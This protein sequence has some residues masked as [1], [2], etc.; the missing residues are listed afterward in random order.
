MFALSAACLQSQAHSSN[1]APITLIMPYQFT[2]PADIEGVPRITK[3]VN[4]VQ[5][6]STPAMTDRLAQEFA[7]AL[8]VSFEQT[9]RV[10]RKAGGMGLDG[11]R[12]VAQAAPDGRTLLFAGN[13]LMIPNPSI[14]GSIHSA[15]LHMLAPAAP[16]AEMPLVLV[17][18]RDHSLWTVRQLVERSQ[19]RAMPINIGALGD[20][21]TSHLAVEGLGQLSGMRIVRVGYN[22]S[23]SV[24]N[25][26]AARN[27]EFGVV[28]LTTV[29][30]YADGG[31]LK[32]IGITSKHRHPALPKVA[33]IAESGIG[34]YAVSG[35]FGLFAP[36]HT[37]ASLVMLLNNEVQRAMAEEGR[38]RRLLA[39]GLFPVNAGVEE[40]RLLIERD[41]LRWLSLLKSAVQD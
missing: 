11:V 31:R 32:I 36:A 37:D 17:N 28:P 25:A 27:V 16:L 38:Q 19:R 3:M 41:T 2:G 8:S 22:S 10:E 30:P 35:W 18:E 12:A 21:T 34:G 40:F 9:V 15:P 4:L 20:G 7:S 26:V 24:L 29:L 39:L 1:A 13:Q 33:T 6:L 23:A 5:R 14:P